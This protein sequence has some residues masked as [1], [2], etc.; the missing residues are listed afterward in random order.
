M[1]SRQAHFCH[2]L[3]IFVTFGLFLSRLSCFCYAWLIFVTICSNLS[4]FGR[5]CHFAPNCPASNCPAPNC[6]STRLLPGAI[7]YCLVTLQRQM[8]VNNFPAGSLYTESYQHARIRNRW[9]THQPCLPNRATSRKLYV[10]NGDTIMMIHR[11]LSSII[12][13]WT[14]TLTNV[15]CNCMTGCAFSLS[16]CIVMSRMAN[17]PA[18][19][20]TLNIQFPD[21]GRF[22][23]PYGSGRRSC[24]AD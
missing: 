22:S 14:V 20:G 16:I 4:H 7:F 3:L 12:S 17:T 10:H 21:Q 5:F 15:H 13:R 19:P 1:F 6:H 24:R 2:F 9:I 23:S 18:F 11:S 8:R